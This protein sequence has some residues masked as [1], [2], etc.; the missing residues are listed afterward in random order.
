MSLAAPREQGHEP[1]MSNTESAPASKPTPLFPAVYEGAFDDVDNHETMAPPSKRA[2]PSVDAPELPRKSA[3]RAS[4]LLDNLGLQLGGSIESAAEPGHATPLDVYLSSEEDASSDADDFSDY[5]YDS[6]NDDP[7]SPTRRTSHEDTARVVSVVFSGKPLII[8]LA[9]RRRSTSPA[10]IATRSS[11]SLAQSPI[12]RPETPASSISSPVQS[13]PRKLLSELLIRKR[14]TF[15]HIDPYANGSSYSL[16]AVPK[17]QEREASP[18]E[19]TPKTPTQLLKG[20]SKT[21]NLVRKRS[22]PNLRAETQPMSSTQTLGGEDEASTTG[23]AEV[24]RSTVDPPASP[25]VTYNDIIRAAKHNAM[26]GAPVSPVSQP[27]ATAPG[28]GAKR[29]ILSGLAAR[30]R[31]IKITG[32]KAAR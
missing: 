11:A 8:D 25:I 14:P 13:P 26:M 23:E 15:L 18:E 17:Q 31:S 6:S 21:F 28:Q 1:T 32:N 27:P 24:R 2:R 30:R 7:T 22:R 3:L 9:L 29:G 20:M 19:K 5:D 10:S 12:D 16:D 4:R